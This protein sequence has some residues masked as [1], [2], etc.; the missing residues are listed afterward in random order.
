MHVGPREV[1]HL[2]D[3]RDVVV[4]DVAVGVDDLVQDREQGPGCR[5]SCS[6]I[7]RTEAARSGSAGAGGGAGLGPRWRTSVTPPR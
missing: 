2:G 6:A 1:E 7:A 3:D 4:V 5:A